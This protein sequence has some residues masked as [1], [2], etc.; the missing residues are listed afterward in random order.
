MFKQKSG[1]ADHLRGVH[2]MGK[3]I[4]CACGM[5]FTSR[6]GLWVHEK[7]KCILLSKDSKECNE[8]T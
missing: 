2:G 8:M 6:K 4:Q 7:K 3:P 5:S 1:L